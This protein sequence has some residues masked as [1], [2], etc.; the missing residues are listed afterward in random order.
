MR[1]EKGALESR[2]H[3]LIVNLGADKVDDD[4]DRG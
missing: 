1:Y 4:K 3:T 2:H